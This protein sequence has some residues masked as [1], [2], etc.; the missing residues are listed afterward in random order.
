M[1]NHK[2]FVAS[3][4]DRD[5]QIRAAEQHNSARAHRAEQR[6]GPV[7]GPL[8]ARIGAG[9]MA[10]GAYLQEHY[11]TM[12]AEPSGVASPVLPLPVRD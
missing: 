1:F 10:A 9:M 7:F 3:Q 6:V 12:H 11:D 8:M 5:S 2:D 4:A